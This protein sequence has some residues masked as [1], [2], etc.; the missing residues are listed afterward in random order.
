MMASRLK[1][2]GWRE[3]LLVLLLWLAAGL[4][5][6]VVAALF[7]EDWPTSTIWSFFE[8]WGIGFLLLILFGF[9]MRARNR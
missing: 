2:L 8:M 6:A 5:G 7:R 1:N 3:A 9:Y 4:A